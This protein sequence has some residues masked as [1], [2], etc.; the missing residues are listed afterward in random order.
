MLAT[1]VCDVFVTCPLR[2][3]FSNNGETVKHDVYFTECAALRSCD[4]HDLRGIPNLDVF[5]Y[6]GHHPLHF[7]R[8]EVLGDGEQA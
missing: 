6:A 1:P 4:T 3:I 8:G 7:R 5:G 2:G